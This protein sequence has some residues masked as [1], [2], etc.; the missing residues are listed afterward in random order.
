MKT[1]VKHCILIS[2]LLMGSIAQA[3]LARNLHKLYN[4][5]YFNRVESSSDTTTFDPWKISGTRKPS[6][7]VEVGSS[8]SNFGGG[9][10]STF[11]SPTVSFMA[12]N[13]L[14]ITAG[15]KFSYANMG[16][17]P[18]IKSV[19]G[20][21]FEQQTS[22]NPTEAFAYAHYQ[23][24]EKLSFYGMGSFGKNQLYISPYKMGVGTTDYSQFSLG[25]DY[26][27][28][29]K[30]SIGASFGVING[31]AFGWGYSPFNQYG[32]QRHNPFF[33]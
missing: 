16:G 5:A 33:P 7:S 2:M 31:P 32:Y 13:K 1:F 10:S 27:V 29:E 26:K 8:Y 25:M 6:Y 22:G 15:G 30:V 14:Q 9:L 18:L 12:T 19:G 24:N 4:P 28:S 20:Q 3:Q 21:F 11:I 17:I 23:L